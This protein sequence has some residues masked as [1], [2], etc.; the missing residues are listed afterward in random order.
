[1]PVT[2]TLRVPPLASLT[3]TT[4]CPATVVVALLDRMVLAGWVR[5]LSTKPGRSVIGPIEA[6]LPAIV[7]PVSHLPLS[8]VAAAPPKRR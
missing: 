4:F 2:A 8:R 5:A 6:R 1:L 7:F 3:W